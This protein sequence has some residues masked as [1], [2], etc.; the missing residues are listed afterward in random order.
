MGAG[1]WDTS[2]YTAA[3][4]A[5]RARGQDDFG[6]TTRMRGVPRDQRTAAPDLDAFGATAREARDSAEHPR[7][8][9]IAVLFDVTGSM[10]QVP[11]TLQ[12]RLPDL[13]GLLTRGGYAQDPQILV[14]AIGD[15]VFDAVPLQVGQFESDNRI[16]A[17]LRDIYLERGGGGD[18]KEGYA[19]AAHFLATRARLDSLERRGRKGY[20]FLIGD[21]A[22]KDRLFASSIRKFV[23]DRAFR[24]LD[25]REVYRRLEEKFHVYFVV[26]NLTAYYDAPWLEEHW[27]DLLG[28]R[29]LKLDD[30]DA[31]CDLIA[32]TVGMMEDAITLDEGLADLGAIGSTGAAAVG[33]ALAGLATTGRDAATGGLLPADL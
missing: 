24:D 27:R 8:T 22:N 19:L 2:T 18:G 31:V 5:R 6:Y 4:A 7:S 11:M 20:C 26:P 33:K 28:E 21:E 13:L 14:G 9:P 1:Q 25:V 23:G 10:G 17:Q 15:D 32:L 30:P 3:A 12:R 29:F 16:D